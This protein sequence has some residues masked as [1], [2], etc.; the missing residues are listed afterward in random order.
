MCVAVTHFTWEKESMP[1][2]V[3][4]NTLF[5]NAN[6]S[7]AIAHFFSVTTPLFFPSLNCLYKSNIV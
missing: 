6:A 3:L 2:T 7:P 4:V 1:I 5:T